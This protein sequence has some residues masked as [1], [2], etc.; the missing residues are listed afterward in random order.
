MGLKTASATFCRFID[1]IVGDLKWE[2][3]LV[4]IDDL[5]IATETEEKHV[6]VF[7]QLIAR[8]H[9]ANL[10]LGAKKCFIGRKSV[11]FL[12]HVVSEEGL[13]PDPSKILAISAL[14]LPKTAKDMAAAI[15]LMGYYR[16]FVLN[17]SKVEAPLRDMR[18]SPERWKGT[19]LYS[20]IERAAFETLRDALTKAPILAHPDW[21]AP[22]EVHTDASHK[23][24]RTRCHPV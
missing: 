7:A 3:V 15:G 14:T 17:Y 24:Q 13:A 18:K 19:V 8:L 6:E 23:R 22:F 16:K 21:T 11:K 4:Y 12:G 9:Q 20:D 5:L 10:T 2:S 1:R